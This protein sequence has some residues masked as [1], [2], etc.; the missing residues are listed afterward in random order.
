MKRA[1]DIE[2]I[3]LKIEDDGKIPNHPVLPF[4]SI[5]MYLRE[6][7]IYPTS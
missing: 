1:E 4:W 7:I 3:P 2:I 5:R 6:A